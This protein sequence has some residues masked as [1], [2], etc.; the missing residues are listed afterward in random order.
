MSV[1]EKKILTITAAVFIMTVAVIVGMF[2]GGFFTKP[3]TDKE[4]TESSLI[5]T[6]EV[7]TTQSQVE[8]RSKNKRPEKI[9]AAFVRFDK[10]FS[11]S[12]NEK[13]DY[14][15]EADRLIGELKGFGFN[16]LVIKADSASFDEVAS[17]DFLESVI[18]KCES[19]NIYT[20]LDFKNLAGETADL[21][22]MSGVLEKYNF[23]ALVLNSNQKSENENTE[24]Y[25]SNTKSNAIKIKEEL[26]K[27]DPKIEFWIH[28]EGDIK[29]ELLAKIS[30]GLGANVWSDIDLQTFGDKEK[31]VSYLTELESKYSESNIAY[32]LEAYSENTKN[33]QELY[34][35]LEAI[36]TFAQGNNNCLGGVYGELSTSVLLKETDAKQFLLRL[37]DFSKKSEERELRVLSPVKKEFIT[38]ESKISFAG[39]AS[40]A[41][42]LLFNGKEVKKNEI[43]DFLFETELHVGE[44]I[45]IFEQNSKKETYKI[46]YNL[47]IL[48]SAKPTGKVQAPGGAEIRIS[49]VAI[50]GA[51]VFAQI[52]SGKIKLTEGKGLDNSNEEK[53][54]DTSS[55]FVTYYADYTLPASKAKAQNLGNIKISASYNGLNKSIS[56]AVVEVL[57]KPTEA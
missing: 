50:R 41:F 21:K 14:L 30:S 39:S 34:S 35:K 40:P 32:L 20:I 25:D 22:R 36:L 55:D 53:G 48:K 23:D 49:A 38:N 47:N 19:E 37:S 17:S 28:F 57:E 13:T 29:P 43:G 2:T 18:K 24:D 3:S 1:S 9:R 44:N 12:L 5:E 45:F 33:T 51:Q 7:E 11:K 15:Q 54:F 52:G 42:P 16:S 26:E 10:G 6:A 8:V 4:K 31:L 56:A 46:T 27:A